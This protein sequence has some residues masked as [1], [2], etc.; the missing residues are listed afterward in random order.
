QGRERTGGDGDRD[1]DRRRRKEPADPFR[2][3]TQRM[4]SRSDH[5]LTVIGREAAPAVEF[6]PEHRGG[7]AACQS[8][9]RRTWSRHI[10]WFKR[11][12]AWA[13][14]C[15]AWSAASTRKSGPL[16]ASAFPSNP[17]KWSRSSAPTAPARPL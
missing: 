7:A 1:G 2:Q 6:T 16:T 3:T 15:G 14:R 9:R 8:S 4:V 10:A 13:G 11:S 12:R 17:A 5:E